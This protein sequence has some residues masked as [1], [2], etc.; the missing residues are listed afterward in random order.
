MPDAAVSTAESSASTGS[1]STETASSSSEEDSDSSSAATSS[2]ATSSAVSGDSGVTSD[3]G[4]SDPSGPGLD[5]GVDAG[6]VTGETI[7]EGADA[8]TD[9]GQVSQGLTDASAPGDGG[10]V[11]F[12]DVQTVFENAGCG[13]RRPGGGLATCHS[14]DNAV[15]VI[16]LIGESAFDALVG[17]ESTT[18]PGHTL[19][20][21]GDADASFLMQKLLN[22]LG[23]AGTLGEPMPLGEGIQ[24]SPIPDNEL[25][26]IRNWIESGANR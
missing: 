16:D 2:A 20:I 21:P 17:V 5:A 19:V 14:T 26:L 18:Y 10:G 6:S 8:S 12:A 23:D 13:R 15:G 7:S 24:W 1:T 3:G 25:G 11:H 22:E 4:S 9:G